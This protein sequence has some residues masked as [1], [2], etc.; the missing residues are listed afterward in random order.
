MKLMGEIQ[1]DFVSAQFHQ[2]PKEIHKGDCGKILIVSGSK[3]MTGAAVFASK[4]AIKAGSGLVKVCI[5]KKLFPIVQIS[6]PEAICVKWGKTKKA[7]M[8]YDA[9]AIGPGLGQRKRTKKML[10][11]ILREY[12]KPLIIDA[13]GLNAIAKDKQL[14]ELMRSTK[15]QTIITPHIGEAKRLLGSTMLEDLTKVQIAAS[16]R[17]H[18]QG[19]TVVKGSESLVAISDDKAYTN[20]TGNPGMATAGS[21]DVLTG[22]IASFVGQGLSPADATICGV[23]IHGLSGDLAA[24]EIGEYGLTAS[25]IVSYV[26]KAMKEIINNR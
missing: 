19:I 6:V 7:L 18:Y 24:E 26:P 25:D 14:Q 22:I 8:D 4:A 16:L 23:Y 9:I 10:K 13:D 11:R 1:R 20:T 12:D 17:K 5:K 15:A 2:R 21:G 3:G